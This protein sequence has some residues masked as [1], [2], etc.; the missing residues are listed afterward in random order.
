MPVSRRRQLCVLSRQ[1]PADTDAMVVQMFRRT[2][3]IGIVVYCNRL[4][5][6]WLDL[7]STGGYSQLLTLEWGVLVGGILVL[8]TA[9]A[10]GHRHDES[11][12]DEQDTNDDQDEP[13]HVHA[14]YS[15]TCITWKD[16]TDEI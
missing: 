4:D 1:C 11:T 12:Q 13:G 3:R 5:E 9:H 14:K 10:N 2:I 16:N 8:A 15:A 6:I 7:S